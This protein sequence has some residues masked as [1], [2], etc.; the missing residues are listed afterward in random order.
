MTQNAQGNKGFRGGFGHS[1]A[2]VL[3]ASATGKPLGSPSVAS[4]GKAVHLT[5]QLDLKTSPEAMT[6]AIL[7]LLLRRVPIPL[8]LGI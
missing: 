8:A 5:A 1:G 2:S 3:L 4:R 6:L 7:S